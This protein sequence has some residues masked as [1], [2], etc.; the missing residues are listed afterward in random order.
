MSENQK[1]QINQPLTKEEDA[2]LAQAVVRQENDNTKI[3]NAQRRVRIVISSG[4]DSHEQCPVTVGVNGRAY[5]IE[6]DKEVEVPESVLHV[7]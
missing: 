5:L 1:V 4:R 2:E 3:L 7:L 6:R